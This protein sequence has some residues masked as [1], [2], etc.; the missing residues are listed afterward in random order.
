MATAFASNYIATLEAQTR[1]TLD[2]A[3]RPQLTDAERAVSIYHAMVA[4]KAMGRLDEARAMAVELKP[5]V[6][7]LPA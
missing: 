7:L 5:L 4:A 3:A 2:M 1:Y 6:H